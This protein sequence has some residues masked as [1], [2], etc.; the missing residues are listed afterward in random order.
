VFEEVTPAILAVVAVGFLLVHL[1]LVFASRWINPLFV[2]TMGF[3][4]FATFS[5]SELWFSGLA[6][7]GRVY[8]TLLILFVAVVF[9]G[10]W[11]LKP[12]TIAYMCFVAV[13]FL[14]SIWSDQV[15]SAFK[16]KGL[17]L[18]LALAGATMAVGITGPWDYRKGMRAMLLAGIGFTG[19][20]LSELVRNPDAISSVGRFQPWDIN[21]NRVGQIAAPLLIMASYVALYDHVKRLK[22]V[23]W[24]LIAAL[25]IVIVYTGSRSALF[26]CFIGV[27]V[28][29]APLVKR[30]I[31]MMA[32]GAVVVGIVFL[33]MSV[34]EQNEAT[35]RLF[36]VDL[37]ESREGKIEDGVSFFSEKPVFGQ[38][39]VYLVTGSG[40]T[41]TMNLHNIY[42]QILAE[43]GAFGG[44]IFACVMAVA[45][46][47]GLLLLRLLKES[48]GHCTDVA[49][50]CVGMTLAVL[51]QGVAESSTLMGATVNGLML[52]FGFGMMEQTI[53]YIR[54]Y[55]NERPHAEHDEAW[56]DEGG[57]ED[58][59][60]DGHGDGEGPHD[61]GYWHEDEP[62]L[63]YAERH[64]H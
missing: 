63:A 43:T 11:K 41:A 19:V 18:V 24:G 42:F 37:Y 38:G 55:L 58:G 9:K 64:D 8:C 1:A 45:F 34:V 47:R 17:Y 12:T 2:I 31:A 29:A 4:A 39:W 3:I 7:L 50:H 52:T 48:G 6:K 20:M 33:L 51:G 62:G 10:G 28:T 23:A 5:A 44:L 53:A 21:P 46:F 32:T 60:W 13:Y 27:G 14:A 56:P 59:W 61:D 30:P 36:E 57:Y 26:M 35:E 22:L 49:H 54:V 40:K 16:Y 15:F 25:A